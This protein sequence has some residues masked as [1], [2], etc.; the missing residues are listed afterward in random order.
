MR[1]TETDAAESGNQSIRLAD[2][3]APNWLVDELQLEFA[4]SSEATQVS[5]RMQLRLNPLAERLE[6]LPTVQLNSGNY[7]DISL[8]IDGETLAP[9]QWTNSAGLLSFTAP[10]GAFELTVVT[11]IN[12][13]ANT[14]LEGLYRSNDMYCTQC[15]AE[16]FRQITAFP[17]R[18]DVL[19]RYQVK[20]IADK[21]SNS[22]LLA[23]GNCIGRGDLADGKHWAQW[24]D[25]WPKPSY[26]FALVAGDLSCVEDEFIAA[27]GRKVALQIFVEHGNESHCAHAMA[28]LK[29][30]MRWDELAYGREYDLDVFMIVAVSHF[31]MGAM[32]NKGLNVFNAQFI[33]ASE[34]TATDDDFERIEAIVA[35]EYF[36]NWSGNRVTCRDWFQLSLK[37]GFT[38]YREQQYMQ[39]QAGA[40]VQR[41]QDVR[42]LR[43]A[44]FPE[45]SGPTA[46]PVQPQ[47]YLEINNMYTMTVYEKGAELVRMQAQ[48]LGEAAFRRGCDLYFERHDGQ[49]VTIEDFSAALEAAGNCD[50]SD[51]RRWYVQAGTPEVAI[52]A[53]FQPEQ[54]SLQLQFSQSTPATP[55]QANK[56]PVVIPIALALL[57]EQGQAISAA[58]LG[59]QRADG[60]YL[61]LLEN[62][63]QSLTITG[64]SARP[65]LSLL[66]GFSAPVR[67]RYAAS[68]AEQLQLLAQDNDAYVRWNTAQQL[69]IAEI[70][71][72]LDGGEQLQADFISACRSVLSGV[73]NNESNEPSEVALVLTT[74][75]LGYLFDALPGQDIEALAQAQLYLSTAL[76]AALAAD[77]QAVYQHCSAALE[78]AE[79]KAGAQQAS[80]LRRLRNLS[81]DYL[82]ATANEAYDALAEQQFAAANNM[83]DTLGAVQ[84]LCRYQRPV[85]SKLLESFAERWAG[86]ELVMDK[87]LSLQAS[88]PAL[89]TVAAVN[90]LLEHSAFD[91]SNPNRVRALIASFA[92][93]NLRAFHHADGS[94]YQLLADQVLRL[95]DINPQ[96]AARIVSGLAR[97]RQL[98]AARGSLMKKQLERIL[99]AP[100]L[101]RNVY[102]VVNRSL[103]TQPDE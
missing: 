87:W 82:V 44:Q 78:N 73:L 92:L 6:T 56:Q 50:L 1:L 39:Q 26:L 30:S 27:S 55:G 49:A 9:S 71:A 17:D 13:Q 99:A 40:A 66:R 61:Y 88:V 35:H 38:V 72:R 103:Q 91:I 23:N 43:E 16:G 100:A 81:L 41:I 83:T 74:P 102:D 3:Q 47:E 10:A 21:A 63:E 4:L 70:K 42:M 76:G 57:D 95:N 79:S 37:E 25:P 29:R 65:A 24:Q 93:R 2:Y 11:L 48:L 85:A 8:S 98:D 64:L 68:R 19:S 28:A 75:T 15:E 5:N 59:E 12:P 80:A 34:E 46:H 62:A 22:V 45:D 53:D 84:A 67:L 14:A 60:S 20:I 101:S 94:G 36:H 51:F 7:L 31:N 89:S 18:P 96:V 69:F 77:W 86:N 32:E 58:G 90:K 33:L 54:Q 52:Q 97:W